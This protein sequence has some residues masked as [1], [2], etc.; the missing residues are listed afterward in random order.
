MDY[1]M[2]SAGLPPMKP[3]VNGNLRIDPELC[4]N[5]GRCVKACFCD[6]IDASENPPKILSQNCERCMFCESVCPTGALKY[7]GGN[8]ETPSGA[9]QS[10]GGLME[11]EIAL[12][13]AKGRFRRVI[14]VDQIGWDTPWEVATTHPRVKDIP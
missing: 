11:H 6:N 9:A 3:P 2:T 10:P 5:C 13:E 14:P 12:A 8:G 1:I 4:I 7:D